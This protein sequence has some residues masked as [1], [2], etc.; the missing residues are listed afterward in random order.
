MRV[1]FGIARVPAKPMPQPCGERSLGIVGTP[2]F[3]SPFAGT[4]TGVPASV[5]QRASAGCFDASQPSHQSTEQG[6][7]A[8]DGTRFAEAFLM[9]MPDVR[10]GFTT[11]RSES[12]RLTRS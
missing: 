6:D 1:A 10:I 2:T 11:T 7:A 4:Q 3:C 8:N 5:R 9:S 12:A